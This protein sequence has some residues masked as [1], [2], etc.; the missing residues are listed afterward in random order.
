VP[1]KRSDKLVFSARISEAEFRALEELAAR[2][3]ITM[4]EIFR[5]WLRTL[6]TYQPAPVKLPKKER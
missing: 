2:D 3:Q 6:P 4:T 5:N 1:R